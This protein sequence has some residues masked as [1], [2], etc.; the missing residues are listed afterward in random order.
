MKTNYFLWLIAIIVMTLSFASCHGKKEVKIPGE[1]ADKPN[2]VAEENP[3]NSLSMTIVCVVP[4]GETMAAKDEVAAL[5]GTQCIAVAERT[6]KAFY[7]GVPGQEDEFEFDLC[8]YS[9]TYGTIRREK[10]T[11]VPNDRVGST[12]APYALA[13]KK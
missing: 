10:M 12:D 2:W 9:A 4:V 3:E 7:L 11:Y 5:I 13:S 6:D 8:Y 1:K